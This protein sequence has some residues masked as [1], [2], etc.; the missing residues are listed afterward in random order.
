MAEIKRI[1][2]NSTEIVIVNAAVNE[3]PERVVCYLFFNGIGGPKV[4]IF[5][6]H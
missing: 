4:G 2:E 3:F 1:R 5:I 6:C